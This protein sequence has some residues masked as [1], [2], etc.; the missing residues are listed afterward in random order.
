MTLVDE[1]LRA[2]A[3]LLPKDQRDDIVAE[4]RDTLLSQ[5]EGSEADLGRPLTDDEIEALLRELGHPLVVAA[6]YRPGPQYVVGP[7][8]Y[9][10]W[11]YG[12]KL[13]VTLG[14]AT[15]ALVFVIMVLAGGHV[16]LALGQAIR[17]GVNTL[18]S[19]VGCATVAAWL[20]DYY[21]LP[22]RLDQ[23]RV[24]DLRF[25][26]LAFFDFQGLQGPQTPKPL[27]NLRTTAGRALGHIASGA[28]LVLWW[29]G[30]LHFGLARDAAELRHAG[31]EPGALGALDWA[32]LKTVLFWPVL[33]YGAAVIGEGVLMLV[34]PRA[35][36]LHGIAEVAT[37][38]A[39]LALVAWL[40]TA[41]PIAGAVRV[42]TF[43]QL[44]VRLESFKGIPVPL[45][46]IVTI[47]LMGV[48]LGAAI[49]AFHGLIRIAFPGLW[50]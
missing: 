7:A 12:V 47:A 19:V 39:L 4:L 41:S 11:M 37:S 40:W 48:A 33:I 25:L 6:R 29:T 15:A 28:V 42:D 26:N 17:S 32:A 23:W 10:Y 5:I 21:G 49:N 36:R 50:R 3:H 27:P 45:A 22:L 30:V 31:L 8:L 2:V 14:L 20:V 34:R 13:A 35:V 24:R 44:L 46:P 9:P 16:G 1:Y 38:V 43:A 18:T